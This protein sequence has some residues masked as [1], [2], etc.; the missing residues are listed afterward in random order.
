MSQKGKKILAIIIITLIILTIFTFRYYRTSIN[1]KNESIISN[2][3]IIA[4]GKI[5]GEAINDEIIIWTEETEN[6]R[7]LYYRDILKNNIYNFAGPINSGY[8]CD[9]DNGN[10]VWLEILETKY[11]V[12]RYNINL[13]EDQ[14]IA[15]IIVTDTNI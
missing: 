14:L 7:F 15:N 9:I 4:E 11:I 1:E 12:H 5:H 2:E 8:T 10:I 6:G 13:N 3:S